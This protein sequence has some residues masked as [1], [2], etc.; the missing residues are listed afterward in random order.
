MAASAAMLAGA[1]AFE[2]WGGLYPCA[3]CLRQREVYWGAILLALVG[4]LCLKFWP[5]PGLRRA[6]GVFL[7]LVFL[8][9]ALVAGYHV[10]TEVGLVAARCDTFGVPAAFTPL[11]ADET[12]IVAPKCDEVAWSLFGISMAG[13]NALISFGLAALSFAAGMSA[14]FDPLSPSEHPA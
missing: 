11:G 7:G 14:R 3:L 10:A 4:L 12:P 9:G 1:H 2:R 8:T 5:R 6:V 13:Y